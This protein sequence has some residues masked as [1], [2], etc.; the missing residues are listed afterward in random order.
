MP[1]HS[2]LA[3]PPI[4]EKMF[5]AFSIRIGEKSRTSTLPKT[6]RFQGSI[7][8]RRLLL[9]PRSVRYN[10]SMPSKKHLKK[11]LTGK[12]ENHRL[13]SALVYWWYVSF[14]VVG[15]THVFLGGGF[16]QGDVPCLHLFSIHFLIDETNA[17]V[18][19]GNPHLDVPLE[20][21]INGDRI[22][23]LFHP[24]NP[25]FISIGEITTHWSDHHWSVHFRPETSKHLPGRST[26]RISWDSVRQRLIFTSVNR[27][28]R[29]EVKMGWGSWVLGWSC[30]LGWGLGW[31][32]RF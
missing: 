27:S 15:E 26:A 6:L 8:R 3:K 32:F 31:G 25:P 1:R 7:F 12:L 13:K 22:S 21:R 29:S 11:T 18:F 30:G 16:V 28:G 9:V 14:R 17:F 23:G 20:V 4:W 10:L 2:I 24:I 19:A 5:D